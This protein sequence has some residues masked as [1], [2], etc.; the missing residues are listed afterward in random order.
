MD[1]VAADLA[2]LVDADP[3]R[4]AVEWN[5]QGEKNIVE[6]HDFIPAL[7]SDFALVLA[8]LTDETGTA[9]LTLSPAPLSVDQLGEAISERL[10]RLRRQAVVAPEQILP[11]LATLP[12]RV[13]FMPGDMIPDFMRNLEGFVPLLKQRPNV[14][15]EVRGCYDREIDLEPLLA[16]LYDANAMDFPDDALLNLAQDRAAHIQY[17]L[18][19]NLG[20]PAERILLQEGSACGHQVDLR[21]FASW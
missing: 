16:R 4:A 19:E 12:R 11:Q 17:F 7:G 9:R 6:L 2:R 3:G 15:L 10:Q 8:L 20:L 21:P 18:V 5:E 14:G 13:D 1:K